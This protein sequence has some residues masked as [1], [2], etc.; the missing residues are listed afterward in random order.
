MNYVA[1]KLHSNFLHTPNGVPSQITAP[2]RSPFILT[3]LL[4]ANFLSLPQK[5]PFLAICLRRLNHPQRATS[6]SRHTI[7][8]VTGRLRQQGLEKAYVVNYWRANM[9]VVNYGLRRR[10]GSAWCGPLAMHSITWKREGTCF[11]WNDKRL[12][13]AS[14]MTITTRDRSKSREHAS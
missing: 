14:H 3:I 9:K 11:I 6:L 4:R 13:A 7:P 1:K 8:G 12:P 2:K 5:T 10:K